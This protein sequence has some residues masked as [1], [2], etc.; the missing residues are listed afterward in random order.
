[1]NRSEASDLGRALHVLGEHGDRL[2]LLVSTPEQLDEILTDLDRARRLLLTARASFGPTG[3]RLHPTGPVDPAAGG[4]C[5]LC[6]QNERAGRIAEQA[7]AIEEA[8][9]SE[10]CTAIA[11]QGQEA[12]E[13]RFGP[14]AVARAIVHCRRAAA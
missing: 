1:M 4:R 9:V 7:S 5:L 14:R 11:E 13:N 12:A 2:A 6:A 8:T 3:C 10:I